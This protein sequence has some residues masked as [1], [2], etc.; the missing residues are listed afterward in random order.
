MSIYT[1]Y[2]PSNLI[3]LL[4]TKNLSFDNKNVKI[5]SHHRIS[6][7]WNRSNAMAS[8]N[9]ALEIGE[10]LWAEHKYGKT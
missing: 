10:K 8:V 5:S 9:N 6:L 4:D 1:K 3:Y 7:G 2:E